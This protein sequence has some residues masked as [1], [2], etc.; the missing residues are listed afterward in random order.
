MVGA[1][2]RMFGDRRVGGV[3]YGERAGRS[4]EIRGTRDVC[5]R[6][7]GVR[8]N[9]VF[10]ILFVGAELAVENEPFGCVSIQSFDRSGC[11]ISLAGSC[12]CWGQV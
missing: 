7:W 2:K 12:R 1:P 5:E 6:A 9:L 4:E 8:I 10:V 11:D 3:G